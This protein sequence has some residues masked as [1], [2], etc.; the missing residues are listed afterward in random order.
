MGSALRPIIIPRHLKVAWRVGAARIIA[1]IARSP[2]RR[3]RCRCAA[4]HTGRKIRC[5]CGSVAIVLPILRCG[6]SGDHQNRRGESKCHGAS[7]QLQSHDRSSLLRIMRRQRVPRIIDPA[8]KAQKPAPARSQASQPGEMSL[9]R[10]VGTGGLKPSVAHLGTAYVPSPVCSGGDKRTTDCVLR[11]R[12][13]E[14]PHFLVT[15]L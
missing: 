14:P 2:E 3:Y 8:L 4:S 12:Y 1:A 10:V 13:D 7:Q 11:A 15:L 9:Y 5:A 6:W